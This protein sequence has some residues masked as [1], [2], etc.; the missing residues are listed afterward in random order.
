[1]WQSSFLA[2]SNKFQLTAER[3]HQSHSLADPAATSTGSVESLRFSLLQ[4]ELLQFDS[5][6]WLSPQGLEHAV[7][8]LRPYVYTFPLSF[9]SHRVRMI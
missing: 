7:S 5:V 4:L 9:D 8:V 6:P 2:C 3:S 1:M